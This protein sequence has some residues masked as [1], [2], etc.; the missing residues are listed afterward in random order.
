MRGLVGWAI[1]PSVHIN[2]K[3]TIPPHVW[4]MTAY[5]RLR[6][7]GA[8][9]FF[10]VCLEDRTSTVLIEHIDLL[11]FAYA[12]TIREMPVTCH[13]MVI[14]PD[15]LHA[16]WTLPADDTDFSER[17][18]RIK[19]RFSHAVGGTLPRCD[20]KIAKRERGLWQRRF[21]EHVVRDENS[22]STAMD[23]CRQNPVMHGMVDDPRDWVYSSFNRP[24]RKDGQNCPSYKTTDGA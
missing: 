4:R 12:K 10:T 19:A 17:W 15:H 11:R 16:I 2:N 24:P 9:Y 14:L 21:W 7:P 18:R 5:R 13:A 6:L 20:S 1:C 22:L 23:Y 8:T 3:L